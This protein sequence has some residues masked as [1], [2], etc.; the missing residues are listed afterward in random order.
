MKICE[1]SDV[2]KE[3][4]EYIILMCS[5]S[6]FRCWVLCENLM[7]EGLLNLGRVLEFSEK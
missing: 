3:I 7:L 1:F 5:F 4:K 2:D 6:L